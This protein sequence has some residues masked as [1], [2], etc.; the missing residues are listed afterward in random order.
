MSRKKCPAG[1]GTK[2]RGRIPRAP[3]PR[4]CATMTVGRPR[5]KKWTPRWLQRFATLQKPSIGAD[6]HDD[7]G[8]KRLLPANFGADRNDRWSRKTPRAGSSRIKTGN[9][10]ICS[11]GCTK[12]GRRDV[13]DKMSRCASRVRRRHH[14][15][16]AGKSRPPPRH[17]SPNQREI[18][19]L[20][21]SRSRMAAGVGWQYADA[22]PS[23]FADREFAPARR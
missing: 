18:E 17:R 5:K 12:L 7:F 15:H 3:R 10:G 11:T 14:R 16:S 4:T 6:G 2:L 9:L 19:P 21:H 22:A 23:W 13:K 8:S 20:H 1:Q